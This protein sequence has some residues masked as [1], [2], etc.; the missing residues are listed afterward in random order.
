MD[1]TV[2]YLQGGGYWASDF[3]ELG[4]NVYDLAMRRYGDPA[5]IWK[6]RRVIR[7][8]AP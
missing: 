6:L 3:R 2:A 7:G 8:S 5:P 4:V 1:V